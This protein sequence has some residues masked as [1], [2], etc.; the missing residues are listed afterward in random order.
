MQVGEVDGQA[1]LGVALGGPGGKGRG[2]LGGRYAVAGDRP[3]GPAVTAGPPASG[4]SR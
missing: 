3:A 2:D 1:L 4:T